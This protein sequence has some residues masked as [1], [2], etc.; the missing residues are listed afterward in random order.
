MQADAA[1]ERPSFPFLRRLDPPLVPLFRLDYPTSRTH[2][3]SAFNPIGLAI[4]TTLHLPFRH[5]AL[6]TSRPPRCDRISARSTILI[7]TL[8]STTITQKPVR[9][10]SNGNSAQMHLS[11][12][13]LYLTCMV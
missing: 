5:P 9:C 2:R 10:S 1:V 8:N 11:S 7:V 13:K 6:T 3:T 12:R 4:Y